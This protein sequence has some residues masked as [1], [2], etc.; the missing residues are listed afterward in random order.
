MLSGAALTATRESAADEVPPAVPGD[1]ML[2]PPTLPA[3]RH[4]GAAFELEYLGA[5]V[6]QAPLAGFSSLGSAFAWMSRF[7]GEVA[8]AP[9]RWF[10]G[11]A[12]EFASAAAPGVGRALLHGNPELWLRGAWAHPT[13]LVAGGGLG[14]M[15]PLPRS[16]APEVQAAQE[17]VR[18]VRAWDAA[19]FSTNE[20]TIRPTFDVR[21]ASGPVTLQFRSGLDVAVDVE[22]LSTNL[23]AR[24]GLFGGLQVARWMCLGAELSEVYPI[25]A[26]IPDAERAAITLSP[27]A[28]FRVGALEPGLSLLVPLSTPLEGVADGFFA[29]RLHVRL[30]FEPSPRRALD[31]LDPGAPLEIDLPA[32]E[33]PQR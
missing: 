10:V 3:L 2:A 8:V 20:L 1:E 33:E 4:A 15:I 13:G 12:W 22:E 7:E 32:M 29:V 6:G 21:W 31:E 19:T 26:D 9:R 5:G 28:R 30:A 23:V 27:S 18:A 14:W 24:A 17:T 25:T 11:G 16:D